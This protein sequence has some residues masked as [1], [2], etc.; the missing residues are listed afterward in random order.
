MRP[1]HSASRQAILPDRPAFDTSH[2][3]TGT[4]KNE[5][6]HHF[7]NKE[8]CCI[9]SAGQQPANRKVARVNQHDDNTQ[10]NEQ[11]PNSPKF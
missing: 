9:V 2:D 11:S 10:E 5:Q 4:K 3:P 6:V 7:A 8:Q 1:E